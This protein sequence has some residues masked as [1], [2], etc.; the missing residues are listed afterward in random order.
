MS[1]LFLYTPSFSASRDQNPANKI[2]QTEMF[3]NNI[4]NEVKLR[5]LKKDIINELTGII[6]NKLS[7]SIQAKGQLKTPLLFI[8]K[9]LIY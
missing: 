6:K 4:S 7:C 9:K 1:P 5:K 3:T 2:I 8:D